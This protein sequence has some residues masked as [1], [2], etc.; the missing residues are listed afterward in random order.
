[1][2]N[3]PPPTV[4]PRRE[5]EKSLFRD[6]F[7]TFLRRVGGTLA[8]LLVAN[9]LVQRY[10]NPYIRDSFIL[11][12]GINITLAVSLNII[13]GYT[14]QFSIGHA[15]FMAIGGYV[16]A[17]ITVYGGTALVAAASPGGII[18]RETPAFDLFLLGESIPWQTQAGA[19][20]FFAFALISGGMAAALVGVLVGLPTLRLRGDYLAIATLGFGEIVRVILLNVEAMGGAAGFSG[21]PPFRTIPHYTT[22]LSVYIVAAV[23]IF[24]SI[25]LMNSAHGRALLAVREDEVAAE[26]VGINTTRYKVMAFALSAFFAG[27]AGGLLGHHLLL[28]IPSVTMFGFMRSIEIVVMVVLGGSGST[29]GAVLGAGVITALPEWLRL[30]P[31][32]IR[33]LPPSWLRLLPDAVLKQLLDMA[34]WRMVIYS[35]LLVAMMIVRRAGIMGNR[36]LSWAG[37]RQAGSRVKA[38][39]GK[40]K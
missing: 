25:H 32:K 34:K 1:M 18:E 23:A 24:T 33:S 26:A 16:A 28:V 11:M 19:Q 30:L 40:E 27:V 7:G 36:E 12:A 9:F 2:S 35:A 6:R 17:A 4:P 37:I 22:F 31:D 39:W 8:A 14:G 5:A 29:T 15:G 21:I 3:P 13:N 20:A 38:R 10:A